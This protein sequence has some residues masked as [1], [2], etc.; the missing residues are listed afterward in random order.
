MAVAS[1]D[2]GSGAASRQSPRSPVPWGQAP[3][4]FDRAKNA[5]ITDH[6]ITDYSPL[7]MQEAANE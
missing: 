3:F 7:N 6:S 2:M 1:I 4:A 5:L